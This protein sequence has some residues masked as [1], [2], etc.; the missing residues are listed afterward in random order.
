MLKL[1]KAAQTRQCL[2]SLNCASVSAADGCYNMEWTEGPG[3]MV[4]GG[5]GCY[6][7]K[8]ASS[9]DLSPKSELTDQLTGARK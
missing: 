2:L 8:V 1:L 3:A 4:N 5:T 9:L 6:N 7:N